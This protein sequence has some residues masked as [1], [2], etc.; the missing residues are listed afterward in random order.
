MLDNL[1]RLSHQD[2]CL[3]RRVF[4]L[5]N[6]EVNCPRA[7]DANHL[8]DSDHECTVPPSQTESFQA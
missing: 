7:R 2:L 1:E 3:H 8:P 5:A 4:V 6:R